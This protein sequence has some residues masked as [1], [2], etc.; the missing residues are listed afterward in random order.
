MPA[1]KRK[2]EPTVAATTPV[3]C[4][5]DRFRFHGTLRRP[6]NRRHVSQTIARQQ[7]PSKYSDCL[8]VPSA[9]QAQRLRMGTAEKLPGG[10]I[11]V[12]LLSRN[13]WR[14]RLQNRRVKSQ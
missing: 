14:L 5:P 6:L 8:V 9:R 13:I 4:P 1:V 10:D 2:A 11:F 3:A 7:G 12:D